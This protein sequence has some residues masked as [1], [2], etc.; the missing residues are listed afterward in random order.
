MVGLGAVET[1]QAL[2]FKPCSDGCVSTS[3]LS[4]GT[5]QT[6]CQGAAGSGNFLMEGPNSTWLL[7]IPC[8]FEKVP[9]N[10]NLGSLSFLGFIFFLL[11][12]NSPI[13]PKVSL[14]SG[15]CS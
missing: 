7:E 4:D 5:E 13:S 6:H 12:G 15:I 9:L 11:R 8:Y 3:L 1:P 2:L 14:G 10:F